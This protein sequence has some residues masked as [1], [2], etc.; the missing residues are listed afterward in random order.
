MNQQTNIIKTNYD[1]GDTVWVYGISMVENKLTEGTVVKTFTLDNSDNVYFIISVPSYIESLLEVRTW[2]TM[3]QDRTGPV[4]GLRNAFDSITT[5]ANH[6]KMSQL[7]Y[8][9][10]MPSVIDDDD[11]SPDE[12]NGAIDRILESSKQ[13]ILKPKS[14]RPK[15]RYYPRKKKL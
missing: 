11:P 12:I 3:S 7:G 6:K 9:Y 8:L 15:A 5:D 13:T 4:G 1:I 2:E 14:P 10:D